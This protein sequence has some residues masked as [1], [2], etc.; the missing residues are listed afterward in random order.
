VETIDDDAWSRLGPICPVGPTLALDII[1]DGM[2]RALPKWRDRLMSHGL[3][4]LGMPM[5]PDALGAA[6][7]LVRYADTGDDQRQLVANA[8]RNALSNARSREPAGTI[9]RTMSRVMQQTTVRVETKGLAAVQPHV[10]VSFASSS[11]AA[12]PKWQLHD[13]FVPAR[14]LGPLELVAHRVRISAERPSLPH[15]A[16]RALKQFDCYVA[17]L[18][19]IR[20]RQ[21]AAVVAG[22]AAGKRRKVRFGDIKVYGVVRP[23]IDIR[24]FARALISLAKANETEARRASTS[25]PGGDVAPPPPR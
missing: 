15:R 19:M 18:A 5:P 21:G 10:A 17:A 9:Q 3:N 7:T 4:I 20:S 12:P 22:G 2:A 13:F 1:D 23:E 25:S 6:R 24:A 16:G 14:D 8:L 11:A